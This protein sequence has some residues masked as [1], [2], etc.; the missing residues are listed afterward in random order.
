MKIYILVVICC[1]GC[2]NGAI[3]QPDGSIDSGCP[4]EGECRYNG[5][6]YASGAILKKGECE[7]IKCSKGSEVHIDLVCNSGSISTTTLPPP[8][9][10]HKGCT[11]NGVFYKDGEKMSHYYDKTTGKCHGLVCIS[12]VAVPW[13]T[14]N[15]KNV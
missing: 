9:H 3:L 12:G 7:V 11:H 5:K 8:T 15:C 10:V 6:C 13:D 4:K 1:F 2:L 14:W